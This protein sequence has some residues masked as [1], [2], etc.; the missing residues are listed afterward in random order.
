MTL[1]VVGTEKAYKSINREGLYKFFLKMRHPTVKGAFIMH[2]KGEL[3]LRACYIVA[4]ISKILGILT[5]E[6]ID[7]TIDYIANC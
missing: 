5:P 3:D 2:E 6:L 4:V 1:L 7:G